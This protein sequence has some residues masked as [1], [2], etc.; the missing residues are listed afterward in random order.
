MNKTSLD[1]EISISCFFVIV[2]ICL[3]VGIDVLCFIYVPAAYLGALLALWRAN[4]QMEKAKDFFGSCRERC[5]RKLKQL[6]VIGFHVVVFA[7]FTAPTLVLAATTM[8]GYRHSVMVVQSKDQCLK[9]FD[10]DKAFPVIILQC[11]SF[12]CWV[13]RMF[14][15]P[16]ITIFADGRLRAIFWNIRY[17]LCDKKI[18]DV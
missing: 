10:I 17:Q 16:T 3:V 12:L 6:T 14:F 13:L 2:N 11:C 9:V 1:N 18:N 4:K 8:K 7:V 5:I 15:D